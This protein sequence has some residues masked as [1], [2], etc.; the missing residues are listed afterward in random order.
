MSQFDCG[1][2]SLNQF[3]KKYA[4]QS[5]QSHGA[6]TY[7]AVRDKRVIGY[8]SVSYGSVLPDAATERVKKGMGKY[9]IPVFLLARLAVD[10][11]CQG[12]GLGYSLL[13]D[14]LLRACKASEE[15]GLRAVVVDAIDQQAKEFYLRYGFEASPID[16]MR[17]F[18]LMKDVKRTLGLD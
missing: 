5:Q 3:L 7:V 15:A 4:W 8:Y 13:Q 9:P 16:E 17:L 14:A 12:Q 18:L 10:K 6:V 2:E 1:K 11:A